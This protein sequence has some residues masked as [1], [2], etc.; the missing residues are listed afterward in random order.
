MTSTLGDIG[1]Y[2]REAMRPRRLVER[3]SSG[4]LPTASLDHPA[5]AH[6]WLGVARLHCLRR[7]VGPTRNNADASTF[8]WSADVV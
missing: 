1:V 8:I 5:I 2:A 3:V 4:P 7:S 6:K